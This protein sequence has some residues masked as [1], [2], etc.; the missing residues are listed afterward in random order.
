VKN[1]FFTLIRKSPALLG[2]RLAPVNPLFG[3]AN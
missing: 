3:E 2:R 1:M